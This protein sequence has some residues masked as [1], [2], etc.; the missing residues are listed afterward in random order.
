MVLL[1]DFYVDSKNV[2]YSPESIESTYEYES[3]EVATDA[4][5]KFVLRPKA[6]TYEFKTD[7]RVPKLGYVATFWGAPRPRCTG[8]AQRTGTRPQGGPLRSCVSARAREAAE[9]LRPPLPPSP[10]LPSFR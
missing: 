9:R 7:R 3:T 2:K 6:E 1:K 4:D 5:G 8:A 10:L